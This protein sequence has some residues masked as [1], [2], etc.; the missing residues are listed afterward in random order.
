[1]A[2]STHASAKS[3][4]MIVFAATAAISSTIQLIVNKQPTTLET[5]VSP[6]T[7]AS[8]SLLCAL[9]GISVIVG[10]YLKEPLKGLMVEQIGHFAIGMGYL[11]YCVAMATYM[12]STWYSSTAFWWAIAFVLASIL[13]FGVIHRVIYRAKRE[14]KRRELVRKRGDTG[15]H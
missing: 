14:V 8:W 4:H 7:A 5:A 10:V 13:R 2:V 6:V 1:M 12:T 9:G 11:A 15:A 3:P